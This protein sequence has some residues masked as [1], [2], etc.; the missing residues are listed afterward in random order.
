M[1]KFL[2]KLIFLEKCSQVNCQK[3]AVFRCND[4]DEIYC[5]VCCQN[6]HKAARGLQTHKIS[7][8]LH[9][10]IPELAEKCTI[11]LESILEFQC[12]TCNKI[13][14]C[15]CLINEHSGHS[16]HQINNLVSFIFFLDF[17]NFIISTFF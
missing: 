2:Q 8:C 6:I 4:C 11:H 3:T 17:T 5:E 13:V 9:N 14:C 7:S 1:S 16:H 12:T 15:Y 10:L